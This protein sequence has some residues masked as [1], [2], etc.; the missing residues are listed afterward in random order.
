MLKL[1]KVIGFEENECDVWC[2]THFGDALYLAIA[3]MCAYAN[4]SC[5]K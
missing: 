4:E 5:K 3:W 1:P 2:W